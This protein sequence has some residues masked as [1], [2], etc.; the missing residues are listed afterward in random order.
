[1]KTIQRLEAL[2]VANALSNL[3]AFR[4][5]FH[6]AHL[7]TGS[8]SAHKTL[9]KLYEDILDLTDSFIE[10]YQGIYGL[11][12]IA[13]PSSVYEDPIALTQ[14]VYDYIDKIRHLFQESWLQNQLDEMQQLMASGLYKLKNLK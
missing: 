9:N 14:K 5:A 8:Y 10:S 3:M 11:Q 7:K 6:I 13:T 4:D 1:M 12:N 2:S